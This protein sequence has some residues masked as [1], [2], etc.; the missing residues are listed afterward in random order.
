MRIGTWNLE[1]HGDSDLIRRQRALIDSKC[2]DVFV[3]TEVH[4]SFDCRGWTVD[5]S[6]TSTHS[7]HAGDSWVAVVSQDLG[8]S[9]RTLPPRS[10]SVAGQYEIGGELLIVYGTVL[11]WLRAPDQA[12]DLALPNEPYVDMF[13]RTVREQAGDL[14]TMKQ[15]HS[16]AIIVWAGDFNQTLSGSNSGGSNISRTLLKDTL[17]DLGLV[18]WNEHLAHAIPGLKTIDLI[19]GPTNRP[20]KAIE[21]FDPVFDGHKLS[22]HAG[23][24]VEI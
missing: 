20:V 8:L 7:D 12:P 15:P 24:L 18:A 23:Y 10:C 9:E 21:R 4:R 1:R 14:R 5:R 22:D 2:A 17:A 11:P 16:K 13:A 6:I 19:C 3:L